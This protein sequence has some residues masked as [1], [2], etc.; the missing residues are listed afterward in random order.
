MSLLWECGGM[1]EGMFA[2]LLYVDILVSA[3]VG[4]LIG[5]MH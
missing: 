5:V 4:V 3:F 2:Q 1:S